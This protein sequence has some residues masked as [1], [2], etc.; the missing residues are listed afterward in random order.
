MA[1][2]VRRVREACHATQTLCVGTSATMA[3]GGSCEEQR[4]E[5]AS[6]ASRL[7]G[8]D[9]KPESIVGEPLKRESL[10][11]NF[12]DA[13]VLQRLKSDV[14]RAASAAIVSRR[15]ERWPRSINEM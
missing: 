6:V 14:A 8:T 7:F 3:S 9:V 15:A 10:V 5:I 1:L 4:I 2:L 13:T 12:A 11:L